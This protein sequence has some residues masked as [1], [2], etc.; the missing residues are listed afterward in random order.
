[1]CLHPDVVAMGSSD[2]DFIPEKL[3]WEIDA[4]NKTGNLQ[5]Y[6]VR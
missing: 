2:E 4:R 5:T 6:S 1:M 3:G